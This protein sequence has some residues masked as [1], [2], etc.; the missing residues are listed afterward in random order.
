MDIF[1]LNSNKHIVDTL[2][3]G[4]GYSP[5]SNDKYVRYLKTGAE[6]F[7]CTFTVDEQRAY[8]II[9]GNYLLFNYNNKLK[10]LQIKTC[11]DE[12]TAGS[13]QRT[14]YAEFVGLELANCVVRPCIIEGNPSQFLAAVLQD[15]NFKVG[16]VS[17]TTNEDIQTIKIDKPTC[18]YTILQDA[19]NIYSNIEYEFEV[20]CINSING[21]YEFYINIYADGER[22]RRTYKRFEYD[23][24]TYG[25]TRKG[26]ISEFCSGLIGTGQNGITFK[27]VRWEIDRGDPL[28]KPLGQDFL[29][30]P[31]A[32]RMFCMENDRPILGVFEGTSDNAADLLWETYNKLQEIKAT[33]YEWTIPV[34]LSNA[35][36]NDLE[37]G[38]TVYVVNPKFTPA[39][40]LEGRLNTITI[41]FTHPDNSEV[42]IANF[43]EVKSKI[44]ELSGNDIISNTIN[45]ILG[46]GTGKLSQNDTKAK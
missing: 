12:E 15:T 33:K 36:Y 8:N 46:L 29:L 28:D 32:H 5:I 9:E 16:T 19:I 25:S 18:V 26:D 22:G 11:E 14:I 7:E 17:E 2:Y 43:K 44:K 27:D 20:K 30:D 4:D 6:T 13:I 34:Y 24:N 40:Q 1:I 3:I 10:M 41:S 23:Y 38:D 39:I 42:I 21:H 35:E 45:S 31:E 37:P